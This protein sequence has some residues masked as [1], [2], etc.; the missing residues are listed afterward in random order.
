MNT[1]ENCLIFF[2][3]IPTILCTV[4]LKSRLDG[5]FFYTVRLP[6]SFNVQKKKKKEKKKAFNV[7]FLRK[8][9]IKQNKIMG[10]HYE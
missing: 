4:F 9:K 10:L 7:A 3:F 8:S 2:L 5:H 6:K 1:E